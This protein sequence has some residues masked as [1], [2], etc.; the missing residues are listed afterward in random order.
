MIKQLNLSVHDVVDLVLR[1]GSLDTR[2]FNQSSMA[3]GTRL[4][5]VFQKGQNSNYIA[6]YPLNAYIDVDD[7]VFYLNG[8]ADGV[9]HQEDIWIIDEIKTTVEK[10][11]LFH[12]ENEEWHLGQ[13]IFYAYMLSLEKTLDKVY[14]RLT[15]I[16]QKSEEEN[17]IFEKAY[18]FAELETYVFDVLRS[19]IEYVKKI[20]VRIKDRNESISNFDF[21]YEQMRS[22]Q[23]EMIKFASDIVAS[24]SVGYVEAPTG[25]GKT[26]SALFPYIKSLVQPGKEKI[27]YLTSKNSI[28]ESVFKLL[29]YMIA[30]GLK[31][32]SV[33]LT[34]KDTLC[35]N[36]K[37]RHC[38]PDECPFAV[39]YYDKV[40]KV[41]FQE[42]ENREIFTQGD[43]LAIAK[44]YNIC[45]FEFQ[46]DLSMYVDI[47]VGDY[48]YVF[49]PTASLIRYFEDGFKKPYLLLVDEAHN[50]PSRTR[51]MYSAELSI[52]DFLKLKKE[53]PNINSRKI[54]SLTNKLID[55]FKD[56]ECCSDHVELEC[57]PDDLEDMLSEFLERAKTVIKDFPKEV[58]DT[59]LDVYFKVNSFLNLPQEDTDNFAYYF[60]ASEGK[61]LSI[62]ITCL[63]SR[64]YIRR[65][66]AMFSSAL[67]FSATL[68]PHNFYIDLLGGNDE[69]NTLYLPSPFAL[70]NR[71]VMVDGNI[72]TYYKDR[73][74]SLKEIAKLIVEVV[75]QKVGNYF[76]FFPSYEYMEKCYSLFEYTTSIDILT[77][78]RNMDNYER[79][80]FL[81]SFKE[82]PKKTTVGFIIMGGIFSE[83]IDL[84]SDRLIGAI[85][86]GVCLPKISYENDLI[87]KHEGLEDS[88]V[89]FNYAYVYPGFN[90]VLQAA[91]RVIR[92]EKDKGVIVLVDSRFRT[93]K[94]KEL[95]ENIWPD[96]IEVNSASE[97]GEYTSQFWEEKK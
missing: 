8:R 52:F 13:A 3:E 59:F 81:S 91:G 27:F 20:E 90:R 25:I 55:Y 53:M 94:Y 74:R 9:I 87:K 89:G 40:N 29:Y 44:E 69:S 14:V 23:D 67:F 63:D 31:V 7:Y 73:E 65:Q 22:G 48:N 18:T 19:Y 4:H 76:V 38:N 26:S 96:A 61:A 82:N 77:Q 62:K 70:E 24:N 10:I 50:L 17:Q 47:V 83:G 57:V 1:K 2:V 95:Y 45:P 78:N 72:S 51:E 36:D 42:L 49:D 54:K 5:S 41:I 75:K 11:E 84:L 33:F 12:L 85:I 86:I 97:A 68:S 21:P 16:H 39:G 37:K 56:Y 30:K 43:I 71:L 35:I 88:D 58:N 46:L 6:E 93:S 66:T 79:S 92:S 80:N 34:S 28:K 64:R 60:V 32:T 15:Y